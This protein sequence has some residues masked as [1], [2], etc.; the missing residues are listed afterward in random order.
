M[1]L[2]DGIAIH[3]QIHANSINTVKSEIHARQSRFGKSHLVRDLQ[4]FQIYTAVVMELGKNIK[5]MI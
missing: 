2:G 5:N 1:C 4:D 3:V